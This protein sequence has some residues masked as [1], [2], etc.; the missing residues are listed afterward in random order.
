MYIYIFKHAHTD[1]YT[2]M[3][4]YMQCRDNRDKELC[5]LMITYNICIGVCVSVPV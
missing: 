4:I 1:T 3:Y 2:H 5:I